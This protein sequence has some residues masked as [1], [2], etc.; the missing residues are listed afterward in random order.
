MTGR[1][2]VWFH[3]PL[4]SFVKDVRT[5]CVCA[6][7]ESVDV[8]F[9]GTVTMTAVLPE[10]AD[11]YE[12]KLT[13]DSALRSG[14]MALDEMIIVAGAAEPTSRSGSAAA[15]RSSGIL[16]A[17]HLDVTDGALQRLWSHRLRGVDVGSDDDPHPD[18]PSG[19]RLFSRRAPGCE[20]R[21]VPSRDGTGSARPAATLAWAPGDRPLKT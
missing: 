1:P 4:N 21:R 11:I 14:P 20:P 7:M 2:T 6:R 9:L 12:D 5:S 10:G 18:R 3:Q 13:I 19:L 8:P 15:G 17:G 16:T